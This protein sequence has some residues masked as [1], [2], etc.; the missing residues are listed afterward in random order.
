MS[1][2]Y[3]QLDEPFASLWR[4][5]DPFVA[6]AAIRGKLY[7]ELEGRRTLRFE[8]GGKA[9]FLKTHSGVGWWALFKRLLLLRWP[10]VGAQCEYDALRACQV[11]GIDTMHAVAYGRR[12]FN[13]ASQ[14]SFLITE[15][16]E[17]TE[18]L[19]R[20]IETQ[21]QALPRLWKRDTGAPS[22]A[23]WAND[24]LLSRMSKREM[25]LR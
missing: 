12:G 19:D 13:P 5:V 7:R 2:E 16:L 8:L 6:V 11:L 3:V 18:E 1:A 22:G 9:Y 21:R 25:L 15:A 24:I 17:P 14:I 20:Y 4:D 23:R 10:I